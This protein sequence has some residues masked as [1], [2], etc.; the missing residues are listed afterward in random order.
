MNIVRSNVMFNMFNH[1]NVNY[2][3]F[4]FSPAS[5]P[6]SDLRRSVRHVGPLTT[7]VCSAFTQD[8]RARRSPAGGEIFLTFEPWK[9]KNIMKNLLILGSEK[10][11]KNEMEKP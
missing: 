1:F 8:P 5:D 3:P 9:S 2:I 4:P 6:H 11:K 7:Q 10:L